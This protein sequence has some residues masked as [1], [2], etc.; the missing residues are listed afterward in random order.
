MY[1]LYNGCPNRELQDLWDARDKAVADLKAVDPHAWC[2]YFPMEGMYSVATWVDGKYKSIGE[3][4]S[5]KITA[6]RKA[7]IELEAV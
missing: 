6:C 4:E 7:I 5:D 3:F 1:K 2:T